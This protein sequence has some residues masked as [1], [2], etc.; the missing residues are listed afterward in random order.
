[1]Q[2]LIAFMRNGGCVVKDALDGRKHWLNE[3]HVWP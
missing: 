2:T 1:M 3:P